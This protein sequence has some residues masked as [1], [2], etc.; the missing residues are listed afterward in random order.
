MFLFFSFLRRIVVLR[1]VEN[2]KTGKQENRKTGKQENRKTGA[3]YHRLQLAE[4][5]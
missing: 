3:F 1:N 2:W 5:L 4:R